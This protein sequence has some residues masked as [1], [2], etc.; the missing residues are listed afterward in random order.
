MRVEMII[1]IEYL[2]DITSNP[3]S[4]SSPVDLYLQVIKIQ[5]KR[6]TMQKESY[7]HNKQMDHKICS[8]PHNN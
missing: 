3:L 5:C 4:A 6:I 8:L 1:R 2:I 7:L